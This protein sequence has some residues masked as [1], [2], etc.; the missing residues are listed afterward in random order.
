M[1]RALQ[2]Q[3]G[4]GLLTEDLDSSEARDRV[5]DLLRPLDAR[6]VGARGRGQIVAG[7]LEAPLG[8]GVAG[9][10]KRVGRTAKGSVPAKGIAPQKSPTDPG[11]G[12]RILAALKRARAA[13]KSPKSSE[14]AKPQPPADPARN[15]AEMVIGV[16]ATKFRGTK[17]FKAELSLSDL[18]D[19]VSVQDGIEGFVRSHLDGRLLPSGQHVAQLN[20][21]RIS[22][23]TATR[24]KAETGVDVAGF[25]RVIDTAQIKHTFDRHGPLDQSDP[26]NPKGETN[27]DQE[28]LS[29]EVVGIYVDVVEFPDKISVRR[30]RSGTKT[31][32]YEKRVNGSIIV[33]EEARAGQKTLAFFTMWLQKAQ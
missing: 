7:V 29:P 18:G 33:V 24:I 31:V 3:Q 12:E 2:H 28:A 15:I 6:N 5:D 8:I 11:S 10:A 16:T 22:E 1:I 25:R 21:A 20:L 14:G 4:G 23:A 27:P 30:R 17:K 19:D 9:M 26:S 32:K 13:N